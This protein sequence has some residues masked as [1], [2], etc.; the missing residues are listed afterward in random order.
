MLTI[1][2]VQFSITVITLFTFYMI[3]SVA[4]IEEF[5]LINEIALITIIP[6]NGLIIILITIF[7]TFLFGLPIRINTKINNWWKTNNIF[8]QTLFL[9]GIIILLASLVPH[10]ELVL[11]SIPY[12]PFTI[13]GWFIVSFCLLHYYPKT[14]LGI[15]LFY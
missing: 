7:A 11:K 6:F 15:I 8:S 14:F 10:F 9:C 4:N 5:D 13:I 2:I 12:I 3:Y 1:Y